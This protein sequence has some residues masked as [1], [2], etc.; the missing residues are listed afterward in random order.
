MNRYNFSRAEIKRAISGDANDTPNFMKKYAFEVKGDKLFFE[1]R[2]VIANEDRNA[3]LRKILYDKDSDLP[4]ARDSLFYLLKKQVIN[5]S[6]RYIQT[7]L[8]KQNVIVKRTAKPRKEKRKFVNNIKKAGS[9]SGDLVHIEPKDLPDGYMPDQSQED[10]N[11]YIPGQDNKPK[12]GKVKKTYYMYNIVDKLTGYLVTEI[13]PS[14]EETIIWKATQKLFARMAKALNTRVSVLFL[15]QGTEF[16]LAEKKLKKQDPKVSVRRMR[17]NALVESVN[18]K[19]QRIFYTIVKQRRSGFYDS[20]KK[21]VEI[22]NNTLNRKVGMTPNEAVEKLL[23]GETLKRRDGKH[24]K[25]ILKKDAYKVGQKVRALK[26]PRAKEKP[27]YKAY[28]GKHYTS[29]Q[30]ITRVVFFQGYPKYELDGKKQTNRGVSL[31]KWHDQI[32]LAQN[33]DMRSKALVSSRRIVKW[34]SPRFR[35]VKKVKP[36]YKVGELVT[37]SRDGVDYKARL[38][39]KKGDKWVVRFRYK[40]NISETT[41]SEAN[42]QPW[43]GVVPKAY[44]VGEIVTFS[45]DGVDYKARL[46]PKKGDKWVVRF[47]YKGNISETTTSEANLKPRT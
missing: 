18:A 30:T 2:E 28:K 27:G 19:L 38:E 41:T 32:S 9:V 7:F 39:P 33:V 47:R 31:M 4:L 37:F 35:K 25:P 43:G 10:M 26:I 11:A 21:A 17:T 20:I 8:K 42:I 5:I 34:V 3:Y 22:S 45:R 1:G 12:W 15:D 40:G 29:P 44:K 16:N 13:V 23:A 36:K 46:E 6:K 14:K 24:P